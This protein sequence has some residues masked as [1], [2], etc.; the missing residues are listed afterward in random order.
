MFSELKT[1]KR[2]AS[3]SEKSSRYITVQNI[4]E[5][6]FWLAAQTPHTFCYI[7]P[8]VCE[9]KYCWMNEL[10]SSFCAISSQ[11]FIIY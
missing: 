2:S 6:A 10:Q 4:L 8:S 1:L 3:D 7:P 9:R 11:C 5:G